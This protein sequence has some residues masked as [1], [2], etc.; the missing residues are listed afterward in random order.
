M[1]VE[2]GHQGEDVGVTE[3]DVGLAAEEGAHAGPGCGVLQGDVLVDPHPSAGVNHS[4][5]WSYDIGPAESTGAPHWRQ[6]NMCSPTCC[7]AAPAR[8]RG[9]LSAQ[10]WGSGPTE[11]GAGTHY[12]KLASVIV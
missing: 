12:R 9:Q 8:G 10:D 4:K 3:V 6:L 5:A 2:V 1:G 11:N 7:G